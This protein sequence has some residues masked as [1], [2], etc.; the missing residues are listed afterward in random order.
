MFRKL[1][2]ASLLMAAVLVTSCS[3]DKKEDNND[4]PGHKV[5]FE[6]VGQN[7]GVVNAA[8]YGVDA[9]T[10]NALNLN[11]A[12]WSSPD[13][14]APAG[15]YNANIVVNGS[16]PSTTS[17]MKVRIYVD[18]EMKKEETASPGKVL[19]VTLGYKF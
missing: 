2:I 7:G 18:G 1:S 16:G 13:V 8:V 15:A 14:T 10:H 4:R 19:S 3:K 5:R 12:N 6:A 17:T 9:D 11:T